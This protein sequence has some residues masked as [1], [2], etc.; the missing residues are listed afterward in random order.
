MLACSV[1]CLLSR[2]PLASSRPRE[3]CSPTGRLTPGLLASG[4]E[5]FLRRMSY[6]ATVA[7]PRP[8]QKS[9]LPPTS[10]WR[11]VVSLSLYS[12]SANEAVAIRPDGGSAAVA[13]CAYS[14]ASGLSC[15][16]RPSRPVSGEYE[17]EAL[18]GEL[19][20]TARRLVRST[21]MKS[22][23]SAET[24]DRPGSTSV[25]FSSVKASVRMRLSRSA[26]WPRFMPGMS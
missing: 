12:T 21:S 5:M 9:N 17:R 8:S 15:Q 7:E 16:F 14:E 1:T 26:T 4:V 3:D 19:A 18:A 13:Y 11:P 25:R 6:S 23:R 24:S 20:V 2:R 22:L 10:A